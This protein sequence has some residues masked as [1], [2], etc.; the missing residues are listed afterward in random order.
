M[1]APAS[2]TIG[3]SPCFQN[4]GGVRQVRPAGS[5][6]GDRLC[7]IMTFSDQTRSI[8]ISG[9]KKLYAAVFVSLPSA[10]SVQH[11]AT[12]NPPDPHHLVVWHDK[13]GW[14]HPDLIDQA[15]PSMPC[16]M[17]QRRWRDFNL[18]CRRPTEQPRIPGANQRAVDFQPVMPRASRCAAASSSFHAGIVSGGFS[19]VTIFLE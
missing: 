16:V 9:Q 2:S 11:S 12:E 6:D 5:Y 17:G 14:L 1:S 7:F 10:A 8:E 15:T 19:V 3:R 13:P 18:S 4:M